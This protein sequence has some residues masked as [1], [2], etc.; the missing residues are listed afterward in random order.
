MLSIMNM[1][2]DRLAADRQ[3][4]IKKLK[5]LVLVDI[6][7]NWFFLRLIYLNCTI[8]TGIF[9]QPELLEPILSRRL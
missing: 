6:L 1:M 8:K 3:N 2:P 9:Y 4:Q 7:L 5:L